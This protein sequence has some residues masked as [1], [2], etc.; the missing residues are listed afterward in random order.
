MAQRVFEI[1]VRERRGLLQ[2][3]CGGDDDRVVLLEMK[4]A[5]IDGLLLTQE[6]FEENRLHVGDDAEYTGEIAEQTLV[7]DG[8]LVGL[9]GERGRRRR[10]GHAR[11]GEDA[12]HSRDQPFG[13]EHAKRKRV[14]IDDERF[15]VHHFEDLDREGQLGEERVDGQIARENLPECVRT[16]TI[17]V[18]GAVVVVVRAEIVQDSSGGDVQRGIANTRHGANLEREK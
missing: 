10:F 18:D 6:P 9:Q 16:E 8:L 13:F 11:Q 4:N 7:L 15:R 5:L 3:G 2:R 1:D 17:D 14:G 12:D